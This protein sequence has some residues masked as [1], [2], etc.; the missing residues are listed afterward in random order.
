L[1]D[2]ITTELCKSAGLGKDK[3]QL[4]AKRTRPKVKSYRAIELY[5]DAVTQTD[6]H[7]KVELLK[8]SLNEDPQFV[9]AARDLD[10]LEQRMKSYSAAAAQRQLEA[11]REVKE[12]LATEK[13]PTKLYL[14]YQQLFSQLMIERRYHHLLVEARAVI[15]NPP[16]PASNT[17]GFQ[18]P[19]IAHFYVIQAF[20]MYNDYDAVLREG[21]KFLVQYPTSAYFNG[22]QTEMNAAIETKRQIAEGVDKA[23]DEIGKLDPEQQRN[24]CK[25]GQILNSHKQYKQARELLERCVGTPEEAKM[26]MAHMAT[27]LLVWNCQSSGDYQSMYKHINELKALSPEQYRHVKHLETMMPVD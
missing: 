1:Q 9:Y 20:K 10:A 25:V 27:Y 13:D 7:K 2:R 21:E 8:L 22:I 12:K 14:Y 24:P 3:A 11:E 23:R 19:E 4:F 15:A 17:G 5:G 26:G 18:V 16:P 6:E